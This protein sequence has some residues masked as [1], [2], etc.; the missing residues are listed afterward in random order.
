MSIIGYWTLSVGGCGGASGAP[1]LV[2]R[3]EAPDRCAELRARDFGVAGRASLRRER[4]PDLH[5]APRSP[6]KPAADDAPSFL[7]V[8]VVPEPSPPPEPAG[9]SDGRI[10]VALSNGHRVRAFGSFDADAL[11]RVVR[12]LGG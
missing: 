1:V 3:R 9:A 5:A 12:V 6:Y 11:C 10:E 2:G 4:Q 7:P 8:E